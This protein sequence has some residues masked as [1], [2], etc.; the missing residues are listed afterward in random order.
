M[1]EIDCSIFQ[2]QQ[3]N[4]HISI[5]IVKEDQPGEK[6]GGSWSGIHIFRVYATKSR[7]HAGS[8]NL[9]GK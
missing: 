1:G 6:D 2:E 7:L 9:T 5:Q 4:V 8:T 3:I